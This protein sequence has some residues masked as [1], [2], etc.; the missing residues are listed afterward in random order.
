MDNGL[1]EYQWPFDVPR[2]V[3]QRGRPMSPGEFDVKI[4]INSKIPIKAVYSPTHKVRIERDGDK[5]AVARLDER[6]GGKEPIFRCY[7]TLSDKAV[8]LNALT[9]RAEGQDG[10]FLLLISP[11]KFYEDAKLPPVD[12]TFVLDC[13][14]S[15]GDNDK[16]EAAKKALKYCLNSLRTVDAF[17]IIR[18]STEVEPFERGFIEANEDNV[19]RAKAFVDG[20][21]VTGGTFIDGALTAALAQKARKD[22]LHTILFITDGMPT[23]GV[24][25]ADD[26]LAN[27]RKNNQER[28]RIF[29]CGVGYDVNTKLL[30]RLA[31]GDYHHILRA[32]LEDD[33]GILHGQRSAEPAQIARFQ[34]AQI[35]LGPFVRPALAVAGHFVR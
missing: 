6:P 32:A 9:T 26:I 28:L 4:D 23:V 29:V 19:K 24:T 20:L 10:T 13:S 31:N 14:G 8:G 12:F 15:M 1:V 30:D 35:G 5:H 16:I 34:V 7:Y 22:R 18:F 25:G 17:N 2:S 27:V 33:T 21:R 3:A 11:S